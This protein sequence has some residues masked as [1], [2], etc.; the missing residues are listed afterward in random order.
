MPP[1]KLNANLK[2]ASIDF[3][4]DLSEFRAQA[5]LLKAL[6]HLDDRIL[7]SDTALTY[8]C[9]NGFAR[10]A[11]I[12]LEEGASPNTTTEFGQSPLMQCVLGLHDKAWEW[13]DAL[14]T[15]EALLAAGANIHHRNQI[16]QQAATWAGWETD[17]NPLRWLLSKGASPSSS[18]DNGQTL[19]H[20]AACRGDLDKAKLLVEAGADLF[21]LAKSDGKMVTPLATSMEWIDIHRRHDLT[22][23]L[24]TAQAALSDRLDLQKTVEP[25]RGQT[26]ALKTL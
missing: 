8:A 11:L 10:H 9:I 2:D 1:P 22:S 7:G 13:K 5:V 19:L 15:M 12:L 17:C 16:G 24:A 3:C 26:K 14:P 6:G 21:A 18:D 25:A 23:Y 4:D 20:D